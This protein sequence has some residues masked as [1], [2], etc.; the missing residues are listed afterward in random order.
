M[1]M[2]KGHKTEYKII[3]ES[4]KAIGTQVANRVPY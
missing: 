4:K 3:E 2:T 1:D